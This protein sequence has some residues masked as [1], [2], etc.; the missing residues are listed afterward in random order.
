MSQSSVKKSICVIVENENIKK[1]IEIFLCNDPVFEV[2]FCASMDEFYNLSKGKLISGLICELKLTMKGQWES[3]KILGMLDQSILV[4]RVKWDKVKDEIV[5]IINNTSF[6]EDTFWN[7]YILAIK[8]TSLS[9]FLRKEDRAQKFWSVEVLEGPVGLKGQKLSTR[10]VSLGGL[11]VI[12]PTLPEL[13]FKIKL[14][15]FEL[16]DASPIE[17]EVKWVHQWGQKDNFPVG[18]GIEFLRLTANQTKELSSLLGY[19][20]EYATLEE[21]AELLEDKNNQKNKT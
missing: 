8:T 9:R 19:T 14:K 1:H 2:I 3:R 7:N 10:D 11:F 18:F 20:T 17:A 12:C 6:E 4:A 13:G 21:L 16:K 5:G 15:I